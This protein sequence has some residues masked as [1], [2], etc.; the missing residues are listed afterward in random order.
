M[1]LIQRAAED[2][3]MFSFKKYVSAVL[4]VLLFTQQAVCAS[5]IEGAIRRDLARFPMAQDQQEGEV[6]L[7]ARALKRMEDFNKKTGGSWQIRL[8]R[9][10]G[11]PRALVGGR[12][13]NVGK[14]EGAALSFLSKNSA[15][16]GVERKDLKL[17]LQRRSAVGR[18]YYFEQY[19]KGLQ[20]ETAYV[21][22]NAGNDGG[23]LNYQS[24]YIP[25][26][27]IAVKPAVEAAAAAATAAADAS[28]APEGAAQLVVY[29]SPLDSK[30]LL[31]WKIIVSGGAAEPG[32]WTYY[33]DA[34]SGALLNRVSNLRFGAESFKAELNPVYPGYMD[35]TTSLDN[36]PVPLPYMEVYYFTG[37]GP[38]ISSGN[39]DASGNADIGRMQNLPMRVFSLFTGTYFNIANQRNTTGSISGYYVEAGANSS[40][41]LEPLP[42][43]KSVPRIGSNNPYTT[44]YKSKCDSGEWNVL[45]ALQI[46]DMNVGAMTLTGLITDSTFLQLKNEYNRILAKYIGSPG[47]FLGPIVANYFR[48]PGNIFA[49]ILPAPKPTDKYNIQNVSIYC[50]KPANSLYT[51]FGTDHIVAYR[52]YNEA[53]ANAYYNLNAARTFFKGLDTGNYIDL[54]TPL[55]VVVNAHGTPSMPN[56]GMP[57]AFYDT[58]AKVLFFGEGIKDSNG[59]Y[60]NF[61]LESAIVRHEYVHAVVDRIWPIR[62]FN[63]GAAISEAV[64]DYFALSSLVKADGTPYTSEIGTYVALGGTGESAARDLKGTTASFDPATWS[65]NLIKGNYQNSLVLSQALWNL[66]T[67]PAVGPVTDQILWNALMFFPDSL[68]EMRDAMI[69]VG[70]VTYKSYIEAAFNSRNI[71]YASIIN[72]GDIYEPNNSPDSAADLD[73]SSLSNKEIYASINPASDMDYYSF[74]LPAGTFT[75]TLSLPKVPSLANEY[76]PLAMVL[77]NA[78]LKTVVDIQ[79]PRLVNGQYNAAT[80]SSSVTLTYEVP[81]LLSGVTGRYILGVFKPNEGAYPANVDATSG[82]YKLVLSRAQGSNV[83]NVQ[84]TPLPNFNNGTPLYFSVPYDVVPDNN[85]TLSSLLGDWTPQR[86]EA[87]HSARLLDENFNFIPG[88]DTLDSPSYLKFAGTSPT[89]DYDDIGK[90]I[91]C[92][93]PSCHLEFDNDFS[94]QG[95]KYGTVYLQIFGK[96]RSDK[97]EPSPNP[98]TYRPDYGLV[99]LGISNPIRSAARAGTGVYVRQSVFNPN[100]GEPLRAEINATKDG[101]LKAQIFTVDGLLVK[102]LHDGEAFASYPLRLKWDGTNGGGSVVASGVYL[103]RCDGAGLSRAVR[104]IVVVK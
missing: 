64:S 30:P 42:Q 11:A 40:G 92:M 102:T 58:D 79:R 93:N 89:P 43:W 69:A 47:N 95:E 25:D 8:N 82:Q 65:E 85:N 77:L 21:K 86:I 91:K 84:T 81:P 23:L 100:S 59:Q 63:E 27:D 5:P 51:N 87:F 17:K 22:V 48:G 15:F 32:K 99:S 37:T 34:Q 55:P 28:G 26:I 24:T 103:L 33:V 71:N 50:I 56:S 88:S 54:N 96:I 4:S 38:I 68:L 2:S 90:V 72:A 46:E 20:V 83:G 16:L 29:P 18:H 75:A 67:H 3:Y 104:K 1:Y 36:T 12:G 74:A 76:Y 13:L 97:S 49:D 60:R 19:Y 45:S 57:N 78:N 9:A 31:A 61:A 53:E 70:G 10:N 101:H 80:L 41:K 73:A 44:D 52:G 35:G 62:Y 66:R 14:S 98:N 94:A 39:T 6:R 7:N